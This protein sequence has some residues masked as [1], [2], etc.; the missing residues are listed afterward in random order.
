MSTNEYARAI[1]LRYAKCLQTTRQDKG[2]TQLQLAMKSGVDRS[3]IS[4][5]ERARKTPTL[6]TMAFLAVALGTTVPEML[7]CLER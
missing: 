3:F 7:R 1:R 4:D 5:I 6:T 2:M